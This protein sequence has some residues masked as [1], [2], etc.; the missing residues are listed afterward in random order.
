M[1]YE[2]MSIKAAWLYV[3]ERR[4]IIMPNVG[5]NLLNF[6]LKNALSV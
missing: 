4:R 3:K 5:M 2:G 6:F 1:K